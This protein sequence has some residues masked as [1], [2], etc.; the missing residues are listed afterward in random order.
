MHL[1]CYV[2]YGH[3]K[4][5]RGKRLVRAIQRACRASAHSFRSTLVIP[6]DQLHAIPAHLAVRNYTSLFIATT[7]SVA[8]RGTYKLRLVL[9]RSMV[10]KT[11]WVPRLGRD[12]IMARNTNS[13]AAG[14]SSS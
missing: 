9:T 12:L 14:H 7:A 6:R 5:R 10:R 2:Y 4:K 8:E 3:Q 1:I 11:S 13:N